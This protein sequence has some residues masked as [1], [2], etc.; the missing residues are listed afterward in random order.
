MF[1]IVIIIIINGTE[2]IRKFRAA[3]LYYEL[4]H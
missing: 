4:F 2:I 3:Y 1:Y